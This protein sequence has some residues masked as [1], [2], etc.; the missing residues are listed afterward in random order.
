[1]TADLKAMYEPEDDDDTCPNCGGE[2]YIMA[3]DGDGNDW[4][5]DTYCG[6]SDAMIVCRHC[7]GTGGQR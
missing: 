4:G 3:A 7:M 6:P 1:M 5:E 2:G